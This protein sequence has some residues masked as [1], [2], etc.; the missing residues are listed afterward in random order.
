MKCMTHAPHGQG[1]LDTWSQ[2]Q[3]I[4]AAWAHQSM[5]R[6]PNVL[7]KKMCAWSSHFPALMCQTQWKLQTITWHRYQMHRMFSMHA[8]TLIFVGNQTTLFLQWNVSFKWQH[9]WDHI[10]DGWLQIEKVNPNANWVNAS[11][12][13]SFPQPQLQLLCNAQC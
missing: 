4:T 7:A 10:Q 12:K 9:F 1:L 8:V 3:T 11:S 2:W 6:K 13:Q 5:I